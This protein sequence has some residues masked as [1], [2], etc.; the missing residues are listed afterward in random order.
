MLQRAVVTSAT[1]EAGQEYQRP[2]CQEGTRLAVLQR[3]LDWLLG[4]IDPHATFLWLYGDARAG[5]SSIGQ[6]FAV[7]CAQQRRLLASFFFWRDGPRRST[8]TTLMATL[9]DQSITVVPALRPLVAAALERDP[10]I[11][12]KHLGLQITSLLVEPINDLLG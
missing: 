5:K 7:N 1:H 6:T 3:L 4:N 8:H 10:S 9:L 2:G 11:L 12:Q